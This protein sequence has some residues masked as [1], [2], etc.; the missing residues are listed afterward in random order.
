[1]ASAVTC[2]EFNQCIEC[3]SSNASVP[4]ISYIIVTERKN[5]GFWYYVESDTLQYNTIIGNELNPIW[6][7]IE[8]NREDLNFISNQSNDITRLY[9]MSLDVSFKGIK[10]QL[11]D[12]LSQMVIVDDLVVIFRDKNGYYW[13]LGET[14]G[15][16]VKTFNIT[17]GVSRT[18][19][20]NMSIQYT[21]EERYPI[22]AVD[23][24]YIDSIVLACGN[25]VLRLCAESLDT[26]CPQSLDD[27]CS[28]NAQLN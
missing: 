7:I 10:P 22:R 15:N 8:S 20:N 5:L 14:S 4:G 18:G 26:L 11:Q 21:C 16:S 28:Q 9:N 1:M 17:T 12:Q 13:C 3:D 24:A 2:I 27:L 23:Q 19:S 25:N 6:Y